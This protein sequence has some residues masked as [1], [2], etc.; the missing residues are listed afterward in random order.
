VQLEFVKPKNTLGIYVGLVLVVIA[1]A[2]TGCVSTQSS[3][4][5]LHTEAKSSGGVKVQTILLAK[6][7]DGLRVSGSGERLSSYGSSTASHVDVEIV[8]TNGAVL[9]HQVTNLTPKPIRHSPR[10]QRH[11]HY[12]LT[13]P[14]FPPRGSVI[15][16]TV[17]STSVSDC[18]P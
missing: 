8:A 6:T 11:F 15:R 14:E 10:V 17:H 13:F 7:K 5:G 1:I 12:A 16:V 3:T 4:L 2:V 9:A 18:Q